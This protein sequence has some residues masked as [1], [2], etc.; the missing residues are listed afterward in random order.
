MFMLCQIEDHI[1][2]E[3][4]Q[5]GIST[6]SAV[7]QEIK[8]LYFDKVIQDVGLV[9]TLYDLL[10]VKGGDVHTGDGGAHFEAEFRLVVFRPYEG[11]VLLGKVHT[12][13][14]YET[15]G[16]IALYAC[17]TTVQTRISNVATSIVPSFTA[18]WTVSHEGF[19]FLAR[20]YIP[21]Q[22]GCT[23][24]HLVSSAH[25]LQGWHVADFG[26]H[27]RRVCAGAEHADARL[28]L[29]RGQ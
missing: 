14:A 18:G 6:A 9:I 27:A 12:S 2:V 23:V 1:R 19:C 11:E 21:F 7:E 8:R 17:A 5:L 24:V 28:P 20:G 25:V 13:T 29:R 22:D 15:S 26:L 4:A 3:P 10:K 16:L